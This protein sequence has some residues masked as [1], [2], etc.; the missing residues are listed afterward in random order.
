MQD[1]K[2]DPDPKQDPDPEPRLSEKSDP[3]LKKSLRIHNTGWKE[4][5]RWRGEDSENEKRTRVE[6]D[7]NTEVRRHRGGRKK[8]LRWIGRRYRGGGEYT[9]VDGR[10]SK[11]GGE[12]IQRK[13]ERHG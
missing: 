7:I 5:Q 2:K 11:G 4:I 3:D 9:E 8:I 12:D 1:P 6:G 10:R 13:R